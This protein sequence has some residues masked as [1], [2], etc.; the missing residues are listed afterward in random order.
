[1]GGAPQLN[2]LIFPGMYLTEQSDIPGCESRTVADA[3]ML[4]V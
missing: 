2:H 1:M 3:C 4:K